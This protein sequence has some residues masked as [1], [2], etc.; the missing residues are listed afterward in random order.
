VEGLDLVRENMEGWAELRADK[1]LNNTNRLN[2]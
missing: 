1:K 2:H